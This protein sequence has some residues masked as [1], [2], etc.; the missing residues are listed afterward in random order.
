M[1]KFPPAFRFASPGAI[2]EGVVEDYFDLIKKV[3][4]QGNRQN[5]IEHFKRY[6]SNAA[7]I[8]SS[9][10]SNESWAISDLHSSMESAAENAATFIEA[11]YDA[12][13]S[14]QNA[15]PELGVPS[16]EMMN[17]I[18]ARHK[19][20]YEIRPPDL[21]SRNPSPTI[22]VM[23]KPVSLEEQALDIIQASLKKSEELL[24]LGHGRQAVQEILWLLETVSTAFNGIA[25]G[26]TTIEGK[27]FN[28]IAIELKK[29]QK[30]KTLEQVMSWIMTL[31]GYLSS[32]TGG[33]VRHGANLKDGILMQPSEAMLFCNLIRSYISYLLSAHEQLSRG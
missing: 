28:K 22:Q 17:A 10:S 4:A 7:G 1:L 12:C 20:G 26:E 16:V 27:Y 30:G 32:P 15:N 11:F 18:L 14:L 6:F 3:A 31:H 5:L 23:E 25:I 24:S 8:A 29:N 19:S 33:G 13:I 21:L 2:A 9:R